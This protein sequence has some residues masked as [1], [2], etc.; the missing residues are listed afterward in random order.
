MRRAVTLILY[1]RDTVIELGQP[2]KEK[3]RCL[4]Y[5]A[6]EK[7]ISFPISGGYVSLYSEDNGN[8]NIGKP[9]LHIFLKIFMYC[10]KINGYS[11][12]ISDNY[13]ILRDV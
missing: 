12:L 2:K 7:R 11:M 13:I 6:I 4:T 1:K 3:N 5:D 8:I 10:F 9:Y